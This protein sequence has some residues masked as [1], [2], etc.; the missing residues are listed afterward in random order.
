M[1]QQQLQSSQPVPPGEPLDDSPLTDCAIRNIVLADRDKQLL[2]ELRRVSATA[3]PRCVVSRYATGWAES[4]EGAM[5]GH[6]S[7]ALLCRYRCRLL[8]AEI[9]RGVERNAQLK[10]RI[11]LW[12]SGQINALIGLV[13]GQQNSGPLRR[14]AET[15]Q[16]QRDEQRGKRAP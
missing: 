2:S 16:P 14:T 5:C 10:Q 13:L 15:T 9:P 12:E 1:D 3:H 4:L 11:Q 8:L 7:W 6:Q